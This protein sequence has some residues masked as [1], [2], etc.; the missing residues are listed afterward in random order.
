MQNPCLHPSPESSFPKLKLSPLSTDSPSLSPCFL[1]DI[2]F[3]SVWI[4][5]SFRDLLQVE[6]DS[7]YLF[8]CL[9]YFIY[10]IRNSS[11]LYEYV[12][13][14]P[15]SSFFFLKMNNIP[16]YGWT[17]FVYPSPVDG[18]LGCFPLWLTVNHTVFEYTRDRFAGN[19]CL[20]SFGIW[21][22]LL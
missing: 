17:T 10:S 12:S 19:A 13:E 15:S 16:L 18:Q 22:R 6:T 1:P 9:A 8:K 14:S 11:I 2:Y 5:N 3:L 7:I 20:Q 4:R 21:N